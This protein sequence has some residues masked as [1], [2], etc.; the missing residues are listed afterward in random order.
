MALIAIMVN[1]LSTT[2]IGRKSS[3]ATDTIR[4]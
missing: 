2:A 1:G 3:N 4:S